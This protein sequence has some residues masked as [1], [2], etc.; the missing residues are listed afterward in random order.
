MDM[1]VE[2]IVVYSGHRSYHNFLLLSV[3]HACNFEEIS[4]E[5]MLALRCFISVTVYTLL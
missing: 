5:W 1:F 4:E 3:F 2:G